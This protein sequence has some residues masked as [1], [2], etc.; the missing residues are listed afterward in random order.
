[1]NFELGA[2]HAAFVRWASENTNHTNNQGGIVNR[3]LSP[4]TDINKLW[5]LVGSETWIMSPRVV[6]Q[7]IVQGARYRNAIDG[8]HTPKELNLVFPR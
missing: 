8:E 6:N 7:L 3:D 1:M 2:G 5:S 4:Q